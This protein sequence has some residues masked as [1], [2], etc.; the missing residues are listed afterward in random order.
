MAMAELLEYCLVFL[1]STLLVAGSVATYDSFS[2]FVTGLKFR[3]AS[4]SIA[5]LASEAVAQGRAAAALA[6]P[7][8]SVSCQGGVLTYTSGGMT[9]QQSVGAA[10]DFAVNVPGGTHTFG[11]SYGGRLLNMTVT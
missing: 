3:L 4:T 2:G 6:V 7:A 9:R 11:F 5:G 10:C 1:V 8:S